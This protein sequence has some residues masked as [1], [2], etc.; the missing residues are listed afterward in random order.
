MASF[1]SIGRLIPAITSTFGRFITEIER[2]EGVPPNMSVR[3]TTPSPASARVDRLDDVAPPL[4][5]VVIR[6]D[7]D[8]FDL[9][10]MADHVLQG[11][12]K[13]DGKPPVGN[14]Y[15]TYHLEIGTPAGAVPLPPH[16]RAP[17]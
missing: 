16:E 12:T 17:S 7:R 6:A 10:L 8:G 14:E 13:L 15:Q 4:L 3:I 11:R 1:T 5:D 9:L 2:F